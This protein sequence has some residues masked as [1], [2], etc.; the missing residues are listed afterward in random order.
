MRLE[1]RSSWEN[2]EL[3]T[4][5]VHSCWVSKTRDRCLNKLRA[6]SSTSAEERGCSKRT[7]ILALERT[8]PAWGTV[9]VIDGV[10]KSPVSAGGLVPA[11]LSASDAAR[12][13]SMSV[14]AMAGL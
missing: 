4:R 8:T 10:E 9:E 3:P 12:T 6:T 7:D 13:R 11:D 14:V 2:D 5:S 1:G